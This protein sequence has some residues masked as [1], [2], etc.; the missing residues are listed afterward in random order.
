[1]EKSRQ[2]QLPSHTLK[3]GYQLRRKAHALLH[4]LATQG[5]A[6][7]PGQT[8]RAF[9]VERAACQNQSPQEAGFVEE[10]L[11]AAE[12]IDAF[13][14]VGKHHC[15]AIE[16]D[17]Q[18]GLVT[19]TVKEVLGVPRNLTEGVPPLLSRTGDLGGTA[20]TSDVGRAIAQAIK[21]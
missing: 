19:D 14:L 18:I 10:R 12:L 2:L 9:G 11:Q 8:Y 16:G 4:G 1:M 17:T 7:L 15:I 3:V 6:C 13:G 5:K 20:G 21:G